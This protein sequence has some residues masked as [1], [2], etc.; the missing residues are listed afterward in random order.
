M[1][2]NNDAQHIT[3]NLS[4]YPFYPFG[5]DRN[6]KYDGCVKTYP[7]DTGEDLGFEEE[8]RPLF[9]IMAC[10]NLFSRAV[11]RM[12]IGSISHQTN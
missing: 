2:K 8:N 9:G 7:L 12:D 11:I 1:A 5:Q 10:S 3:A 6:V 4:P